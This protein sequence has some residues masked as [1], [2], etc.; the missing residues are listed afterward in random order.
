MNPFPGRNSVIVLDN[1]KIHHGGRLASLC[2]AANV[3][4]IYL[5]PYSP[6][7]NPIEKVFSVLKSKLKRHHV[8][9][10]TDEDPD[11]IKEYLPSFVT[12]RLMSSLFQA[13][14]YST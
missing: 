11:L 12:P 4:L 6:D 7:L 1:A 10:G 14:G 9:T 3:L 13:S 8:L 5:P 2:D